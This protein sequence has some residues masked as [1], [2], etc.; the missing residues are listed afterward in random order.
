MGHHFW[1]PPTL[2]EE[3]PFPY[4]CQLS[5]MPVW[6]LPG[7]SEMQAYLDLTIYSQNL[8]LVKKQF[9]I[10]DLPPS[11]FPRQHV[12]GI[13][14]GLP[15]WLLCFQGTSHPISHTCL[16]AASVFIDLGH[17]T[18]PQTVWLGQD[19]SLILLQEMAALATHFQLPDPRSKG[20]C[21]C[22]PTK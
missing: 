6:R 17:L 10:S 19:R 1:Q 15:W 5:P 16:S 8:T 7:T 4:P 21:Q 12:E 14:H 9:E 22:S 2:Q 11:P 18:W 3:S 13:F 20:P